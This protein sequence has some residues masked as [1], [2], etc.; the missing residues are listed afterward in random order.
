MPGQELEKWLGDARE[1]VFG[2][3]DIIFF[4]VDA[5]KYFANQEEKEYIQALVKLV[6]ETRLELAPTSQ[7]FI[8]AHKIDLVVPKQMQKEAAVRKI[9]NEMT[10]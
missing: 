10:S 6:F 4:V 5:S 7:L 2:G 8:L 9:Q 3:A 1:K